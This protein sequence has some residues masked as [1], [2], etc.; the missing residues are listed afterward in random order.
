MASDQVDLSPCH[1]L[2]SR[3]RGRLEPQAWASLPRQLRRLGRMETE[4][5][6]HWVVRAV[7]PPAIQA[8]SPHPQG[9]MR[10]GNDRLGPLVNA[11]RA[12]L[13]PVALTLG[14]GVSAPWRGQIKPITMGTRDPVWPA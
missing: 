8:P 10:A 5:L 11:A 13:A 14:W 9:V 4:G 12:G 3:R 1:R 6:G 7:E 2:G